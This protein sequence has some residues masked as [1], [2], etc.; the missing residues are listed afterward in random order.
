MAPTT[1][2]TWL[3]A[4]AEGEESFYPQVGGRPSSPWFQ[5][6]YWRCVAIFFASAA[7]TSP[8]A[9]RVLWTN[10]PSVPD[11]DGHDLGAF[12]D[13]LGVEVAT[14][15]FT[16]RPPRGYYSAWQNQFYVLDLVEAL[17]ERLGDGVGVLL[18]SDCVWTRPAAP[19]VEAVVERGALTLDVGLGEDEFQNGLTRRE[20]GA[21]Y[22][23]LGAPAE[24][25]PPYLGGEIVAV[26]GA[27]AQTLA[28]EARPVWEEMLRRHA[29]GRATFK[30]EAHLLS[31][32]YHRLGIE[33]GT[34]DPFIDR[35]YTSLKDGKT[36]RPDHLDLMLWHLPNEKRYGLR[37]LFPVVLDR[38]SWF[39]ALSPDEAWRRR[40]GAVLGVPQRTPTKAVL[41]VGAAVRDKVR[42]RLRR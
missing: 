12:L 42:A 23:D 24:G 40:L 27:T 21:L 37:R 28:R 1:I 19:L 26:T 4:E 32:L 20:M 8:D 39:W 31:F 25:V 7:R 9:A 17:G 18:D 38:S 22:A 5:A 10:A 11:V 2:A 30:E 3:Y 35:I 15:P 13:G 16:Y 6:V 41:D 33:S 14:R 36:V 29:D 34:A